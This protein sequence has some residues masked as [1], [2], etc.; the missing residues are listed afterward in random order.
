[1]DRISSRSQGM[2]YVQSGDMGVTSL[3]F[4]DYIVLLASSYCDLQCVL[5]RF[6]AE[7]D[8]DEEQHLKVCV[9]GPL[10]KIW[11]VSFK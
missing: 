9:H 2:E 1:M 8:T 5:E 10:P 3:L 11:F 7:C 4:V 6:A